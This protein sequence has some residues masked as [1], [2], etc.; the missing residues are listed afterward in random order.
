MQK[1]CWNNKNIKNKLG[2]LRAKPQ[3]L[4]SWSSPSEMMQVSK[5]SGQLDLEQRKFDSQKDSAY[6]I[7]LLLLDEP[8]PRTDN[9]LRFGT[10]SVSTHLKL[11]SLNEKTFRI[12]SRWTL[13]NCLLSN[14]F[15]CSPVSASWF[16][17]V[18]SGG[19]PSIFLRSEIEFAPRRFTQPSTAAHG[20]DQKEVWL[21]S[22]KV[23]S[24]NQ[25]R[26]VLVTQKISLLKN[27]PF[28]L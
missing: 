25:S 24:S 17:P 14:C 20:K 12:F 27:G 8:P 6:V 10:N 1:T 9:R 7:P 19:I 11:W 4:L 21:L 26:D 23:A 3:K 18:V 15:N 22:P 13:Q 28:F 2:I 5:L 16:P